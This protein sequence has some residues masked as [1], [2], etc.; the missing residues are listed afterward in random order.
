M[1]GRKV[2]QRLNRIVRGGIFYRIQ[3]EWLDD[4]RKGEL[5]GNLSHQ[6]QN[7]YMD[8]LHQ[9]SNPNSCFVKSDIKERASEVYKIVKNQ[10]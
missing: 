2:L 6:E 9:M 3:V 5:F 4:S 1:T 10:A 7:E 8:T